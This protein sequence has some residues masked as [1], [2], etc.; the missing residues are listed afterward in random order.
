MK[1]ILW[2]FCVLMTI[3]SVILLNLSFGTLA[4]VITGERMQAF[5]Y[6]KYTYTNKLG[7][8]KPCATVKYEKNGQMYAVSSIDIPKEYEKSFI[9]IF[10]NEDAKNEVISVVTVT[11]HSIYCAIAFSWLVISAIILGA[12]KRKYL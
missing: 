6:E 10:Y 8:E 2:V 12:I 3:C 1:K 9:D 7:V 4:N 5:V 11:K